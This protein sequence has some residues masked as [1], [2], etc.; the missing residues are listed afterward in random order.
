MPKFLDFLT[1]LYCCV[2]LQISV[3]T[4]WNLSAA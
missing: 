3:F 1:L 2:L 4:R